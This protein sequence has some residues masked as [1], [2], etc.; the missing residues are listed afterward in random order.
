MEPHE[1]MAVSPGGRPAR[2]RPGARLLSRRAVL[3]GLLVGGA[4]LGAAVLLGCGKRGASPR[5]EVG[6]GYAGSSGPGEWAALSAAYAMCDG[7]RQSPVDLTGYTL[8]GRAPL[9]FSY[10]TRARAVCNDGVFVHVDYPAGNELVS[11]G[12][13]YGLLSAHVHAPSEHAVEGEQFAAELHLVHADADGRLAVVGLLLADGEPSPLVQVMLDAAPAA[14]ETARGGV[15]VDP[16]AYVPDRPSYFR[17][18]GSKTTPPCDEEVV[19]HVMR[20]VWTIS[21]EQVGALLALGGGPTNRPLQ[22]ANDR[23]ITLEGVPS[24]AQT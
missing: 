13:S 15:A 6:W 5:G 16:G 18:D 7:R 10:G 23:L 14:G 4:G 8:G 11:D 9:A 19:W 1:E 12:S 3:R 17:Y 2:P 20:E 21:A 22:P 24:S